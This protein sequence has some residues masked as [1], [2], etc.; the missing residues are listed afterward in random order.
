MTIRKSL[1]IY[2]ANHDFLTERILYS[3]FKYARPSVWS[4]KL[5]VVQIWCCYLKFDF[6]PVDNDNYVL[7]CSIVWA[8]DLDVGLYQRRLTCKTL[9]NSMNFICKG[10]AV[11]VIIQIRLSSYPFLL[12]IMAIAFWLWFIYYLQDD[13]SIKG[14]SLNTRAQTRL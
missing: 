2:T 9:I 8:C 6:L 10:I 4:L 1:V 12:L 3:D 11:T 7:N 14:L 13:C 5:T